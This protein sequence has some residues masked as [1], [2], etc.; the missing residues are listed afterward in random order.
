MIYP[1]CICHLK[2]YLQSSTARLEQWRVKRRDTEEW[3]RHRQLPP[4]LQDRVRRF[5]QYKWLATRGVDEEEILRAL[6]LDI[7]R[8][9]Q[10]H[11]CLALVRRVSVFLL[12]LECQY[13][14]GQICV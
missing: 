14:D 10:R 11:L 13:G 5:V 12:F 2:T 8:Q 4:D 7:R 3:M 9:I 1:W 6:P